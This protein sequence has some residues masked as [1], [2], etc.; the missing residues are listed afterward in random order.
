V[1][2][3]E[4]YV[5]ALSGTSMDSV[6]AVL[7]CFENGSTQVV[8]LCELKY[9]EQLRKEVYTLCHGS[10]SDE[11]ELMGRADRQ[12]GTLFADLIE[13]LLSSHPAEASSVRAIGL[14]GQ[15]IRHR[16]G[17]D[18]PFTLQITDPHVVAMRT[19]IPV[20]MDFRRKD[21]ACGGEGAPLAP[22]YHAY[23]LSKPATRRL[24]CNIGG[25]SNISVI[26]DQKAV[27]GFDCGVGNILL[28]EWHTR[29]QGGAFDDGGAWGRSGQLN[30]G[31]LSA[32]QE[33]P[34]LQLPAN[35]RPL[36]TGR[37]EFNLQWLEDCLKDHGKGISPV[38]IQATL[39][40]FTAS[41]IAHACA[42]HLNP[43]NYELDKTLYI[44]GGGA[45]NIYLLERLSASLAKAGLEV[46]STQALG[47]DPD[48]VETLAFAWLA[49]RHMRAE[50]IDLPLLN[51]SGH[52]SILGCLCPP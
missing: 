42:E 38:D 36:S 3:A 23:A 46:K 50:P 5:G 14:H 17:G 34:F 26:D 35:Q 21:I 10:G 52:K 13:K 8:G 39:V 1:G 30:A 32:L 24:I 41:T 29:H 31:L 22:I 20:V 37:E 48:Q 43:E 27:R 49:M 25:I 16:P 33:H 18:Y 44:C 19:G 2:Q 51:G 11:I 7:A 47:V 45:H 12:L 9:P 6:S 40:E 28:D 4:Y 15:T